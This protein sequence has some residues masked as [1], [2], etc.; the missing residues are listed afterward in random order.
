ML[1]GYLQGI[2][3]A[4]WDLEIF[5]ES[6]ILAD[7]WLSCYMLNLG[8]LGPAIPVSGQ[9]RGLRRW[10][11]GQ[12]SYYWEESQLLLSEPFPE[13]KGLQELAFQS[14]FSSA[15]KK[16][17]LRWYCTILARRIFNVAI[18]MR[19]HTVCLH[20]FHFIISFNRK[21]WVPKKPSSG[22]EIT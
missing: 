13:W 18:S 6:Q 14:D 8:Q 19:Q 11:K 15:Y 17:H 1:K 2:T 21:I 9:I 10:R 22:Q 16:Q 5:G 12:R 4:L 7:I 3:T 20:F